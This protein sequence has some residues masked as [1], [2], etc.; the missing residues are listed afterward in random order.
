MMVLANMIVTVASAIVTTAMAA[1]AKP[2]GTEDPIGM[3]KGN[4][5]VGLNLQGIAEINDTPNIIRY[6][7]GVVYNP[8][9]SV[10]ELSHAI[11]ECVVRE[12]YS[13]YLITTS[14]YFNHVNLLSISLIC[15]I[16]VST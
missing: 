8:N 3:I 16:S 15:F 6:E 1:M 2:T 4:I 10:E 12:E 11:S 7:G 13:R 9:K 5:E 14:F